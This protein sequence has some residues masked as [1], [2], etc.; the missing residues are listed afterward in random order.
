MQAQVV[1]IID[2]RIEMSQKY[3]KLI[4]Q[5]CYVYAVISHN[6][7]EAF[8]NIE[9]LEPDLIIVSDNFE[10]NINDLC[11]KIRKKS[12]LYRP[13]LVALSKSSYLDDKLNVI[14]AGADDF[15][16][17]PIDSAEFSVR[18]FAH[19]RRHVEELSSP[20]TGLPSANMTYKV[21]NR[22]IKSGVKW[23]LL[24][25]DIDD[26]KSYT[27]IYG[28]L[29]TDKVMKTYTAILK[30]AIDKGDYLGHIR[31][32]SF[33]ILT[34]PVKADRIAAFLN[35]AFDSV[36]PRFYNAQDAKRGYL[37]LDGD[38]R[39]GVKIPLVATSIGIIS[40][41][42][43]KF[44]NYQEALNAVMN[45]HKLAKAQSGSSW[46]SDRPKISAEDSIDNPE[47]VKKRILILEADA[48][49]AYLLTTTLEMQGYTVEATSCTDEVI[50]LLSKNTP[51]L[52]LLDAGDKNPEKGLEICR[53]IKENRNL[54]DIKIIMSTIIHDKEM[55]LDAGAD[56]Y[57]P[58]PY[59]LMTLF[60]WISRFLNLD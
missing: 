19:L 29:A 36:S 51:D 21:I 27:D 7:D 39:A 44:D 56:L 41:E 5:D 49:L 55:V 3:K 43:R 17:E 46:I 2:P 58:K 59:E 15:M 10:E 1:L 26:L 37:I 45:T 9:E 40:N 23:S 35:F 20:V 25:L 28:Y 42:H 33:V 32:D 18:I 30:S 57:L 14:K 53:Q 11:F 6:L 50:C 16:S 54:S 4:Q 47:K 38:E 31:E 13:V 52:L 48:A 60:N 24:Y 34:D 8:K 12:C 22:T